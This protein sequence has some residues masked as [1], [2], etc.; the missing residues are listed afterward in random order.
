MA[1]N[2]YEG[3]FSVDQPAISGAAVLKLS[4]RSPLRFEG[5]LSSGRQLISDAKA[6]T[7]MAIF[8]KGFEVKKDYFMR[9]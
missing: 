8:K 9:A 2:Q 4:R 7:S 3:I 6:A 1:K 5:V